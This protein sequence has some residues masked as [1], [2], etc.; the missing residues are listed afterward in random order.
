MNVGSPRRRTLQQ[1]EP[2]KGNLARRTWGVRWRKGWTTAGSATKLR[3]CV[4]LCPR[5]WLFAPLSASLLA[6]LTAGCGH[7]HP[8]NSTEVDEYFYDCE[9]TKR[10]RGLD[11][12]RHRR[13]PAQADRKGRRQGHRQQGRGSGDLDRAGVRHGL[14]RQHPPDL[15]AQPPGHGRAARPSPC[16]SAHHAGAR[17]AER[18]GGIGYAGRG[19]GWPPS[20]PPTRIACR[21]PATTIWF[22]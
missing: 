22:G 19:P 8:S 13:K 12:V 11:R 6:V 16:P 14:V 9:D 7:D 10:P 1:T 15:P 2:R 20:A 21:S 4:A 17:G 5:A 3:P 18:P